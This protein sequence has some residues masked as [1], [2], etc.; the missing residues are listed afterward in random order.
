MTAEFLASTSTHSAYLNAFATRHGHLILHYSI[1][2]SAAMSYTNGGYNPDSPEV[3][4]R[5]ADRTAE[6][7]AH[8]LIPHLKS[9]NNII[10]VG[11]GPGSITVGLAKRCPQGRTTG[12]DL[13]DGL[14]SEATKLWKATPNL[15]FE[16]GNAEDLSQY[17][18][19]SFDV[20]HAHACVV[21]LSDPV[22]AFKEF[23]RICKPG[24]IVATADPLF[25]AVLDIKPEIPGLRESFPLKAKWMKKQGSNPD[26]GM[27]K[28]KWARDAG[29]GVD[30]GDIKVMVE[31]FP[32]T[33]TL[34]P[35]RLSDEF[36]DD[37][38][39]DGLATREQVELWQDAWKRWEEAEEREVVTPHQKM[40]CWKA[41]KE[42]VGNVAVNGLNGH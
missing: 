23:H 24:G 27:E 4:K 31:G 14:I 16:V 26:A 2:R 5:Y 20:V 36:A 29:F 25:P 15:T 18:D 11:C 21:H 8:Y 10:D 33:N 32:H 41:K 39:K 9:T 22:K 28:E 42:G 6:K 38:V 34:N 1:N 30:G 12:V 35:L 17:E 7:C 13:T 40:L 37:V 3:W 19:N